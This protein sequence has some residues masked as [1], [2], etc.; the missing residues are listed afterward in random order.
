MPAALLPIVFHVFS[1][2][3]NRERTFPSTRF[4]S[5]VARPVDTQRHLS[6]W[7]LLLLRMAAIAVLVLFAATPYWE[8][9]AEPQPLSS[10][11]RPRLL[12]LLDSSASMSPPAISNQ[13]REMAL[14]IIREHPECNVVIYAPGSNPDAIPI[15]PDSPEAFL[16]SWRAGFGSIE[17]E[18]VNRQIEEFFSKSVTNKD[19]CLIVSDFQRTEWEHVA[20]SA[21]P[22]SQLHFV[23]I[24][25]EG[26]TSNAAI[27]DA[28]V[29]ILPNGHLRIAATAVNHSG[30]RQSRTLTVKLGDA[31]QSQQIDMEPES[32]NSAFFV[33]DMAETIPFQG[34]VSFAEE[35]AF[36]FDDTRPFHTRPPQKQPVAII[37][38]SLED[39][40]HAATFAAT[41]FA[42]KNGD[43]PGRFE[44]FIVPAQ[45]FF[46]ADLN[47]ANIA[48]VCGCI[49]SIGLD[50]LQEL[51]A[52]V[53]RGGLLIISPGPRPALDMRLLLDNG[54]LNGQFTSISDKNRKSQATGIGTINNDI[55]P[56]ELFSTKAKSDIFLFRIRKLLHYKPAPDE[57]TLAETLE[58]E[59]AAAIRNIE[60]GALLLFCFGLGNEDSDFPM[61]NSFLP[62]L[63]E[64]CAK[65][66]PADDGVLHLACASKSPQV[67]ALD[68]RER[69]PAGA[70]DTS[71]PR[72]VMQGDILA[73][74]LVPPN[75]SL[76]D[77]LSAED[78]HRIVA[79][80][81]ATNAIRPVSASLQDNPPTAMPSILL[82]TLAALLLALP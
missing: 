22:V 29:S 26:R 20:P 66:A 31:I 35:D 71:R 62:L 25:A 81:A 56:P 41:A 59:C 55:L 36:P 52:F 72:I 48:V 6:D 37:C 61:T 47:A 46:T 3:R 43:L 58:G 63:H 40:G 11:E 51:I 70:I 18:T 16:A 67:I 60:N 73:E 79:S 15:Q 75:E 45:S 74:I 44:P 27:A 7:L 38:N 23:T 17:S 8:K 69:L 12:L 2:L 32:V 64:I 4:L 68:G 14:S 53:K 9:K 78:M 5:G 13:A 28:R 24:N 77:F 50:G 65:F 80:N 54:F 34:S 42:T 1:R 39:A 76:P 49:D 30:T 21:I 82:C 10:A 57:I 33:F 19:S